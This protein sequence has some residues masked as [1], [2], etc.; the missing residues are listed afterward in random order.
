[1]VDLMSEFGWMYARD[2]TFVESGLPY[3]PQIEEA[4][5]RIVAEKTDVIFVVSTAYAVAAHRLTTTTPIVMFT[6]GYPVAAGLAV[7]LA[8]P[9]K[10]VTGNTVYAGTGIW[11]KLLQLLRDVRPGINRIGLLWDYLP[12]AFPREEIDFGLQEIDNDARAL[13]LEILFAE[14][15]RPEDAGAGLAK[16]DAKRVE[17]LLVTSGPNLFSER[18]RAMQFAVAQRIPTITDNHWYP[19]FEPGPLMAYGAPISE[20]RRQAFGYID[21]I[22][23]GA[24]AS[25]L[26]IQQPTRFELSVNLK[27]AA[28]IGIKFP[29]SILVRADRVIE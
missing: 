23:R 9:G 12:P 6:S 25:N 22:L 13:G 24:K 26:P 17:A 8:R 15:R 20:L 16:L 29:Q 1:M 27:T 19:P 11:G 4:V 18:L 3:G 2:Y 21:R 14:V 10:N 28:A 7:S 5:R